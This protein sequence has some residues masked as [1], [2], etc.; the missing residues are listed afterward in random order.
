MPIA[1]TWRRLIAGLLA[2]AAAVHRARHRAAAG[3]RAARRRSPSPLF[4]VHAFYQLLLGAVVVVCAALWRHGARPATAAARSAACSPACCSSALLGPPLHARDHRGSARRPLDDPQGAIAFLP[5][6]Q[7]GL[8][9]A[10][11]VAA[12]VATRLDALPRRARAARRATQIA[13]LLGAARPGQ[14]CR[15]RRRTCATS[16]AG[17]IAGPVL[18]VADGGQRCAAAPLKSL[19]VSALATLVTLVIAAPVLR[20]PSERLFGMEIVG[21]PSRSVHGDGSSSSGRSTSA[22]TRSRSPTSPGALLARLAGAGRRVQLAGASQLSALGRRR[23]PARAPSGALAAGR[24]AVAALAYAFSPFHLAHAAYHPHIAQTQWLPLYLLALWRCLDEASPAA[25]A[26]LAA[27][28]VGGDAL[29]LLR[30][31]DRRGHHAGRGRRRTG[32]STR[33][34]DPRPRRRLARHASARSRSSPAPGSA[35]RLVHAPAPWSR[36]ARRSR[37]RATICSATA[38][39]G[40]ATWCRR[41]RIRWLGGV[42]RTIWTAAGVA[43]R[44]ARTAGQPR[45][46]HRRARRSSR[47]LDGWPRRAAAPAARDARPGPRRVAV[48]RAVC[49]LSPERTI[50]GVHVRPPVGAALRDR[51]R[52][53]G[54]TRGSAWS[55]S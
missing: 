27:A 9:L 25:V 17:R 23:V 55:C 42:A 10:L 49:S 14:P 3:R 36:T 26:L 40:G 20:A 52:C 29:E 22:S 43:R 39:S 34:V 13:G 7:V 11:W 50:G 8:Y 18:I 30:R 4:C 28:T 16:A 37:S 1:P 44:A 54:R 33:A 47:S 38:R 15:H 41:S 2:G 31:A 45:L 24:D 6:F 5:A 12:F 19:A 32:S 48:G 46:G 21:P 51:R 53:S 35:Y